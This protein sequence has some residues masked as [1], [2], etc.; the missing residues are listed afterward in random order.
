V[1][2]VAGGG[3]CAGDTKDDDLLALERV[4]AQ[5]LGDAAGLGELGVVGAV[6]ESDRGE[7]VADLDLVVL[8]RER[9]MD[10]LSAVKDCDR[11]CRVGIM[12]FIGPLLLLMHRSSSRFICCTC[13]CMQAC[14]AT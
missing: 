9:D 8:E 6:L 1:V 10:R 2:V 13:A 12:V 14:I 11:V 7:S 3:E 4:G 5:D